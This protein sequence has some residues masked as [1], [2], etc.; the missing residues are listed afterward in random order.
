[1]RVGELKELWETK[2]HNAEAPDLEWTGDDEIERLRNGDHSPL[3]ETEIMKQ[4][5]QTE[6]ESLQIRLKTI[7]NARRVAIFRGLLGDMEA[8]RRD[9]LLS[10]VGL[11]EKE[12]NVSVNDD[13]EDEESNTLQHSNGNQGNGFAQLLQFYAD[14]SEDEDGFGFDNDESCNPEVPPLKFQQRPLLGKNLSTV[15]E[16]KPVQ[17][18][19]QESS[20]SDPSSNESDEDSKLR[21]AKIMLRKDKRD[22]RGTLQGNYDEEDHLLASNAKP[23]PRAICSSRRR[24]VA[25]KDND[26]QYD[27]SALSEDSSSETDGKTTQDNSIDSIQDESKMEE[28]S[29]E[30][31]PPPA[32]R[33]SAMAAKR[34]A[35]K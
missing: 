10:Q 35:K 6:N 3:S 11:Q 29:G 28:T 31:S 7:S 4:A 17:V 21:R 14:S 30:P 32:V 24:A 25:K 12:Q 27:F 34:R 8:E 26:F 15:H 33:R 1:M 18:V 16:S 19:D 9:K 20:S 13:E 5:L 23:R 2:Y 22:I